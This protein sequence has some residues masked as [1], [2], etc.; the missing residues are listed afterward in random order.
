MQK[1]K[2]LLLI[3]LLFTISSVTPVNAFEDWDWQ[4]TGYDFTLLTFID[5]DF[6]Q[7][8]TLIREVE[9][10]GSLSGWRLELDDNNLPRLTTYPLLGVREDREIVYV[11]RGY[12]MP[13]S[14]GLLRPGDFSGSS[15]EPESNGDW[16]HREFT[17]TYGAGKE[18]KVL[19][20]RITPAILLTV[21]SDT[22]RIFDGKKQGLQQPTDSWTSPQGGE[23]VGN[24][25]YF[26]I[27]TSSGVQVRTPDGG[28]N[29]N[30]SDLN[31][32]WFLMWF[33]QD[34]YLW[35]GDK[36]INPQTGPVSS[37]M[38]N[39][40]KSLLPVDMPV[41]VV[42]EK[43][44]Q[45]LSLDLNGGV[46]IDYGS[47]NQAGQ[48]A[49]MPLL[50]GK[51][52]YATETQS[53]SSGLPADILSKSQWWYEHLGQ[54]P[55]SVEETYS[56]DSETK[57]VQIT[58]TFT[59]RSLGHGTQFAP[60]SPP[61]A[62]AIQAGFPIDF[63]QTI[64]DSGMALAIGPVKGIEQS[65]SYSY[66]VSNLSDYAIGHRVLADTGQEPVWL[67]ERF[68]A[69][70]QKVVN[71]GHLAPW[72]PTMGDSTVFN[73]MPVWSMPWESLYYL[74]ETLPLLDDPLLSGV[75]NYMIDER[76]AYAP[77]SYTRTVDWLNTVQT[78]P[79]DVGTRREAYH[80]EITQLPD[81]LQN[82]Y[83]RLEIRPAMNLYSLSNYYATIGD[84]T[85]LNAEWA[86]IKDI[87]RPYVQ[88]SDWS[89]MTMAPHTWPMGSYHSS[90]RGGIGDTNRFIGGAIGF[91]RMAQQVDD[92]DAADLGFYLFNKAI[93][94][95]YA[96]EKL[97]KY[98]YDTGLQTIPSDPNWMAQTSL[99][100]HE[101]GNA[102]LWRNEWSSY[103]DDIR[104]PLRYD[105]FGLLPTAETP[106]TGHMELLPYVDLTPELARFL[107]DYGQDEAIEWYSA[108]EENS[109]A[110]YKAY[111]DAYLGTE[112]AFSIPSN[113]YQVFKVKAWILDESA[114]QLATYTDIPWVNT[115]DYYY[116][117]KLA[118]TIKAYRG[119]TWN[120]ETA[121]P[122]I[123][124]PPPQ[125]KQRPNLFTPNY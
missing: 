86:S 3:L 90:L 113:A 70:L 29:V 76:Q 105:Q 93:I 111:A 34:T 62:L 46:K 121:P 20:S 65:G 116:I 97:I 125:T 104:R 122:I 120:N 14:L 17:Y 26:A 81:D 100:P 37:D 106:T 67:R 22:V 28:G 72:W 5:Y 2:R 63:D 13:P 101:T 64:T 88:N 31:E 109:P 47:G 7:E 103:K 117:H 114:D 77:E 54:F 56:V 98:L 38:Y 53:W 24:P 33:G 41:L 21:E 61:V 45:S 39:P 51:Y 107:S 80:V 9:K 1:Y 66:T 94:S 82:P 18:F 50:G 15:S 8:D 85:E 27:P 4:E 10:I 59:Y 75:G 118:E 73:E 112:A 123:I 119:I 60:I 43:T 99:S 35:G 71:S 52:P 30:L 32:K 49:I 78:L 58:D 74:S 83:S 92:Q 23:F 79:Y 108:V 55:V 57:N 95:R 11:G 68:E 84:T 42:M 16:V 12:E 102:T 110:W 69:E 89:T 25:S 40:S 36:V 19:I 124:T 87:L 115:G 48:L 44:P 96:Q 91:I 6:T